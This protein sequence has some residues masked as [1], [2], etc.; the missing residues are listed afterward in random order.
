MRIPNPPMPKKRTNI[1]GIVVFIL[2]II[3]SIVGF[4]LG[5]TTSK[6]NNT[7]NNIYDTSLHTKQD[8]FNGKK[9]FN[10]LLLGTDTG[11]LGRTEKRGN[12]DTIIIVS[13]N[14]K[15]K[16]TQF[17]SIPRDTMSEMI[18]TDEFKVQKINAA[19]NLGGASMSLATVHNLLNVPI[20]YYIVMNMGGLTKMVN[21]VGGVTV[22]PDLTFTYD[23]HTFIKGKKM[24]LNG[25]EALAYARMRYDDPR[26]DYGRQARQRQIIIA[27]LKHSLSMS[28]LRHLDTLLDSVSDNVRTNLTFNSMLNIGKNYRKCL[29]NTSSDYLHGVSANIYNSSYQVMSDQELQRTSD[30]ARRAINLKPEKIE[31]NET[32]QNSKNNFDWNSTDPNQNYHIFEP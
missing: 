23:H 19:Y 28:T 11:A 29:D 25:D 10:I 9:P 14:P 13:V 8:N 5:H 16:S 22:T 2:V 6:V 32:Y 24:H 7:K 30:I 20:K 27:L 4:Y 18:G 1:Y 31:N 26:G 21:S 17:L 15:T 3:F 12:S